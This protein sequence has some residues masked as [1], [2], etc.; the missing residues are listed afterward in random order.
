M[1]ICPQHPTPPIGGTLTEREREKTEKQI[2]R[3]QEN[4][5]ARLRLKNCT[6]ERMETL[7]RDREKKKKEVNVTS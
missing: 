3:K 6:K 1:A 7:R 5:K 2:G 4:T